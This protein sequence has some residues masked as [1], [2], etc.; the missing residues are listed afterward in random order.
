MR[1]PDW[2]QVL[3]GAL[4]CFLR[5]W[6]SL[7]RATNAENCRDTGQRDHTTFV[8]QCSSAR[9]HVRGVCSA[10]VCDA[11]AIGATQQCS[12][13]RRVARGDARR[14]TSHPRSIWCRWS[15]TSMALTRKGST[16]ATPTFSCNASMCT[17]TRR[18]TVRPSWPT[19]E[20]TTKVTM[21]RKTSA[22]T[23]GSHPES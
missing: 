4:R 13:A 7:G 21:Q 14:H 22:C 6:S 17:S 16:W 19:C 12:V 9:P 2:C 10:S 20:C 23:G 18:L 5:W 11:P 8:L 15:V 3:G 1:Q